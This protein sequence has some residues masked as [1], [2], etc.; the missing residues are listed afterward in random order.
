MAWEVMK[1][2]QSELVI[3][4]YILKGLHRRGKRRVT[5]IRNQS[6]QIKVKCYAEGAEK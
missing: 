6:V 2:N 3:V 5:N 4:L 1:R